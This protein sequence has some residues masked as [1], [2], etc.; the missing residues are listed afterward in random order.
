MLESKRPDV[1]LSHDS[2]DKDDLARPLAHAVSRLGLAAWY[3]EFS[4]KPG[5][6]LSASIDKGL[7]EC[8]HACLLITPHF[9]GN[10]R[11][12]NVEMSTLLT[13]A[14]A[15]RNLIIPVWSNVDAKM[16]AACSARL[17]DLVA[18][19]V[20]SDINDLATQ[21]FRLVRDASR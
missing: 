5:D 11:W 21:I 19:R 20:F 13:R 16:V 8:R 9:L 1:F 14:V 7:T 4:L 18:I 2:R 12:T 17:A 3:D 10:Q 6:R 15:E